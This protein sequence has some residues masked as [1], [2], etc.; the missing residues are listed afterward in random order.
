MIKP[1]ELTVDQIVQALNNYGYLTLNSEFEFAHK[2]SA[3]KHLGFDYKYNRHK[4][5]IGLDNEEQFCATIIFVF[6]GPE[7]NLC[8]DYAGVPCFE[9]TEQQV[10]DYIKT[11]NE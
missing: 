10:L 11:R 3:Y 7:G 5:L 4:Y 2:N 8:G 6:L 9:G 1:S